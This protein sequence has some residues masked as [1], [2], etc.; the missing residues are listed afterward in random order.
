MTYNLANDFHRKQFLARSENLLDKG[1]VDRMERFFQNPDRF[2][3]TYWYYYLKS[4]RD[5]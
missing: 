4:M 3:N 1:A 2:R 5:E